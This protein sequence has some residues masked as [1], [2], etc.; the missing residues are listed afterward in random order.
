MS[1]VLDRDFESERSD[2]SAAALKADRAT[3]AL[4][5]EVLGTPSG[6]KLVRLMDKFCFVRHTTFNAESRDAV[7]FHEGMRNVALWVHS[8]LEHEKEV[9]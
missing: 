8:W 9:K 2:A 6:E 4:F 1:E 3:A 7:I 5:R